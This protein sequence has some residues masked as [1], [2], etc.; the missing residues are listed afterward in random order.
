M[1]VF[2]IVLDVGVVYLF[3]MRVWLMD[4]FEIVL[5]VVIVYL[6]SIRVWFM[7][8]FFNFSLYGCSFLGLF[9]WAG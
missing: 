4:V 3:L 1:D 9:L 2:E 5:D 8:V 6:F 7:D